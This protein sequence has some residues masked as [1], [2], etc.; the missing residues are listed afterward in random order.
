M[1]SIEKMAEQIISLAK[2]IA[3]PPVAGIENLFGEVWTDQNISKYV[4]LKMYRL[5]SMASAFASQLSVEDA[6]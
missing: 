1:N 4:A 3:E 6:V 2:E 5:A